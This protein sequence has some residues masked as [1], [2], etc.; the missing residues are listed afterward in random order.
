MYPVSTSEA[1][2]VRGYRLAEELAR[3]E[4]FVLCRAWSERD[5]SSV[6]VKRTLDV[7]AADADVARLEREFE[8]L[9]SLP[10]DAITRPRHFVIEDGACVL[11]LED[12]GGVTLAA[13]A[14]QNRLPLGWVLDHVAQLAAVL[15]ELHQ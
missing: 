14:S 10:I 4:R 1:P 2:A 7:P 12:D 3:D 5:R 9:K 13:L 6:L 11:V 8:L 15:A